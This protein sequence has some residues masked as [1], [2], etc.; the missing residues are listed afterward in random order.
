[1]NY[2]YYLVASLLISIIIIR[3][4]FFFS[5]I[6]SSLLSSSSS[7][8]ADHTVC[9]LRTTNSFRNSELFRHAIEQTFTLTVSQNVNKH[10]FAK[11]VDTSQFAQQIFVGYFSS[12]FSKM[13]QVTKKVYDFHCASNLNQQS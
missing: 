7:S 12:I 3:V 11:K 5:I 10:P 6:L 13:I 9:F 4:F 2:I 1:M 8:S